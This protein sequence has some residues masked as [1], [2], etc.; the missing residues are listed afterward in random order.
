MTDVIPLQPD[1]YER[2][3][4]ANAAGAQASG[5]SY[6]PFTDQQEREIKAE[7]ERSAE[8]LC[9][10]L[11]RPEQ[12]NERVHRFLALELVDRHNATTVVE[13]KV[14]HSLGYL[15][16]RLAFERASRQQQADRIQFVD[17]PW[18]VGTKFLVLYA[19]NPRCVAPIGSAAPIGDSFGHAA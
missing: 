13:R 15:K 2:L 16:D 19:G 7:A 8:V 6:E 11:P 14:I 5:I 10:D 3:A 12:V 18:L 17:K 9:R 1:V 4:A